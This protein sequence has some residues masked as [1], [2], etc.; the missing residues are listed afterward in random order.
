MLET[1]A[2]D[3]ADAAEARALAA[4][5]RRARRATR[6]S[7]R[8]RGDGSTDLH[9]RVAD[10]VASRL[11]VYLDAYTS[12]RRAASFGDV[13]RLPLPRRRG[14]AFC[15]CSNRSPPTGSRSMA[16]SRPR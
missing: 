8:P 6:L 1:V 5:E 16:A 9:A 14:E 4:E 7:L 13:D 15:G 2:P 10:H 3:I 11:S 12:P